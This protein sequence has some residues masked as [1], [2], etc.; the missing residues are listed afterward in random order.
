VKHVCLGLIVVGG[1]LCLTGCGPATSPDNWLLISLEKDVPITYKMVSERKTE[2]DLT[3]SNPKK[4]SAPKNMSEKLELI[5]VYTPVEVDPFG[6]SVVEVQCTSAKV[7]RLGFGGQKSTK[8]V[9]ETLPGNT[10][11]LTLT[12]TGEIADTTD[13]QRI[14]KKLG[15][16]SFSK[17]RGDLRTKDPDMIGD[18]LALQR[19][20]WSASAT[21]SNQL[22]LAVGDTWQTRQS[23]PWPMPMYPPPAR[24]TTYTLDGFTEAPDQPRKAAISSTYAL[25]EEPVEDYIKP[26]EEGRFQ[27]RGM[28]GFLRNYRFKHLE[29]SGEQVFN[30]DD[31]LVDSDRQQYLLNVDAS[32]MLPLPDSEPVLTV[33]QTFVIERIQTA[34]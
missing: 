19:Y 5:M 18:F 23:I 34:E 30:L 11:T 22:N 31:G 21:I 4:K 13:L 6:L 33:E 20:L 25:S 10:F 9:M 7:T 14:A 24:V 29:G 2:L 28:F 32:F 3:T 15:E 1:V 17:G 8:D 16:A 27:M 12:P 26:Y